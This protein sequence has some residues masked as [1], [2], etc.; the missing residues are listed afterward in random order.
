MKF[1]ILSSRA[2]GENR[3]DVYLRFTHQPC[4][5]GHPTSYNDHREGVVNLIL[6]N[7]RWVIDDFVA[8]YENDELLR[9]SDGYPECKGGQWVGEPRY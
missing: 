5:G 4:C 1:S 9:P 3:V 6:E 7:N 8:V 2:I